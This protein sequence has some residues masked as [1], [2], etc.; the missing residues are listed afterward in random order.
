[1]LLQDRRR[2]LLL[3]VPVMEQRHA[4]K[5]GQ[6]GPSPSSV[7]APT[8]SYPNGNSGKVASNGASSAADD[9]SN[10]FHAAIS[11]CLDSSGNG[12]AIKPLV[13]EG[14]FRAERKEEEDGGRE[15]P[16]VLYSAEAAE[17]AVFLGEHEQY[18]A[19]A[20]KLRMRGST[21]S[22]ITRTGVMREVSRSV[23]S[24]LSTLWVRFVFGRFRN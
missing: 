18:Y 22:R 4:P 15:R 6:R 12:E 5:R 20:G 8:S 3:Q 1:M 24:V 14:D 23:G 9:R 21:A 13:L 11:P 2:D 16:H 19:R 17:A 10:G 7:T